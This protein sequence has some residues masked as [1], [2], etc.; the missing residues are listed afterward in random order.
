MRH[1]NFQAVEDSTR[2]VRR[3]GSIRK[4]QDLLEFQ[5]PAEYR[6]WRSWLK[7]YCYAEALDADFTD[8]KPPK[9]DKEK[10]K[11]LRNRSKLMAIMSRSIGL[12]FQSFLAGKETPY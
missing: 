5:D 9:D 2:R 8:V 4:K 10:A 7:H 11:I 1:R 12:R 3:K 6:R